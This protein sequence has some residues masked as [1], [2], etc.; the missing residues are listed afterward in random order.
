MNKLRLLAMMLFSIGGLLAAG[1][2]MWALHEIGNI[3]LSGVII[4]AAGYI[5]LSIAVLALEAQYND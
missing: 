4:A 1:G 2:A 5:L 3:Y